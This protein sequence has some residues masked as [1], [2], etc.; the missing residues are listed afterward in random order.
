MSKKNETPGAGPAD[1]NADDLDQV[2]GGS[3]QKF[4]F[5][6]PASVFAS[7][8][9]RTA[10]ANPTTKTASSKGTSEESSKSSK[11]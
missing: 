3:G 7:W 11:K 6:L 9:T 4:T 10:A 5:K 2:V 8:K 1:L